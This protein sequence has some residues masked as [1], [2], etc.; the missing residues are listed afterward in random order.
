MRN[1]TSACKIPTIINII[2]FNVVNKTFYY[3]VLY[4]YG[5]KSNIFS[6]I[7]TYFFPSFSLNY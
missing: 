3:P 7:I 1:I 5:I 4:I 2:K 6:Y